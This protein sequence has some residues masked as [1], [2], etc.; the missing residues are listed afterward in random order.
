M[1]ARSAEANS[2]AASRLAIWLDGATD[3]K[4]AAQ[5]VASVVFQYVRIVVK[6]EFELAGI[7]LSNNLDIS[8]GS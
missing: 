2:R 1:D 4:S 3:L 7:N 8:L 6:T 5:Q